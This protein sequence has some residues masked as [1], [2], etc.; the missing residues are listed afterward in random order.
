MASKSGVESEPSRQIEALP[1]AA[2]ALLKNG[3]LM[4]YVAEPILAFPVDQTMT[5]YIVDTNNGLVWENTLGRSLKTGYW[6]SVY[7][8][9][10]K[11]EMKDVGSSK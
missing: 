6:K 10:G 9:S 3:P 4:L 8:L 5:C 7:D 11:E 1:T 2:R